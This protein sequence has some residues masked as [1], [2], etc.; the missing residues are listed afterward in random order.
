LLGVLL[1]NDGIITVT[2]SNSNVK[3]TGIRSSDMDS[4]SS[5]RI[6]NTLESNG[7]MI[8]DA[9]RLLTLGATNHTFHINS[10]LNV[11]QGGIVLYDSGYTR[12]D[13]KMIGDGM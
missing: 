8:V 12:M 4:L 3:S 13:G 6:L 7:E 1:I 9:G 5:L 10:Q 11:H 2:G